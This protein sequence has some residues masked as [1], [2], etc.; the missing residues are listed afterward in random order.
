[1]GNKEKEA[2]AN[3]NAA[4]VEQRSACAHHYVSQGR[5]VRASER[6][7]YIFPLPPPFD[8]A[9]LQP[10]RQ[11]SSTISRTSPSAEIGRDNT[12]RDR[13]ALRAPSFYKMRFDSKIKIRDS[14]FILGC[15]QVIIVII[16]AFFY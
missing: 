6:P 14:N 3:G 11:S 4:G 2:L 10:P 5:H 8:L 7:T 15:I 12:R 9:H 13:M 1:M 16:V